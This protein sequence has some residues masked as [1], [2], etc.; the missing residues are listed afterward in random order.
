MW[1]TGAGGLP[2]VEEFRVTTS[3]GKELVDY[4]AIWWDDQAK[5]YRGIWCADFHRP[6]VHAI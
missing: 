2:L 3:K 1:R 4:A 5:K 6:G